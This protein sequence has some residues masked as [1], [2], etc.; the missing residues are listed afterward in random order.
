M[1]QRDQLFDVDENLGR[2]VVMALVVVLGLVSASAAGLCYYVM[3][4]AG[5]VA[6][7]GFLIFSA[8]LVGCVGAFLIYLREGKGL[9]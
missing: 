9:Y 6:F 7:T 5:L 3:N 1:R 4:D 2:K 8:V